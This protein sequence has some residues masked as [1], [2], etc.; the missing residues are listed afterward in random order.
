MKVAQI[1]EVE[2]HA[3]KNN[4]CHSYLMMSSQNAKNGKKSVKTYIT[5]KSCDFFS[6]LFDILVGNRIENEINP[7]FDVK[8]KL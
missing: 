4:G 3:Q 2:N 5:L 8:M 1:K 7:G 6:I